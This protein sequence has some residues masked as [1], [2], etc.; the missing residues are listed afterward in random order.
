[1]LQVCP[2]LRSSKR[3]AAL[4]KK[5]SLEIP[6]PPPNQ[7]VRYTAS[8]S[9]L[10]VSR[11]KRLE[12]TCRQDRESSAHWRRI[13]Q[14]CGGAHV[15]GALVHSCIIN[16]ASS[17]GESSPKEIIL[18]RRIQTSVKKVACLVYDCWLADR[19]LS[20]RIR[21][22]VIS[23]WKRSLLRQCRVQTDFTNKSC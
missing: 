18:N 20:V 23:P 10:A 9:L 7:Q 5:K 17:V 21:R 12:L 15:L 11:S 22:H 19:G 8:H 2:H 1:M 16:L 6:P 14:Q 4:K 3:N 13:Q